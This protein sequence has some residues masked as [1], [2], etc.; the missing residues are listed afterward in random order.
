MLLKLIGHFR[1]IRDLLRWYSKRGVGQGEFL[2]KSQSLRGQRSEI[3]N[4]RADDRGQK[5]ELRIADC[6]FEKR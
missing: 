1:F 6:G 5:F 4:Q 3:R 2:G